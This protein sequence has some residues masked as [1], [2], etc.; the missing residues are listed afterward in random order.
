MTTVLDITGAALVIGA[1]FV[2]LGLAAALAVAGFA[3]L[4]ASWSLTG[5]KP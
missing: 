3:C 5:G 1:A 4:V 2:A